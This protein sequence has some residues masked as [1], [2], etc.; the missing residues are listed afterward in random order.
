MEEIRKQIMTARP[1]LRPVTIKNYMN[2]L[3]KLSHEIDGGALDHLGFLIDI[4][5]VLSHIETLGINS[6]NEKSNDIA[7]ISYHS[8][9]HAECTKA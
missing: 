4:P 2:Q 9:I 6:H 5:N 7:K 1:N 3:N 8:F